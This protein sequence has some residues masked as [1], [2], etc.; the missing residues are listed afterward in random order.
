[1]SNFDLKTK[2]E[3]AK[4]RDGGKIAASV[5]VKLAELSK[6]GITTAELDSEAEKMI[7]QAGA[8]PSF[9]GFSGY[10]AATCISI[11]DEIVHGIPSTRVVKEGDLIGIDVGVFYK[12]FHTDT[13]ITVGVG[14]ILPE[15]EKLIFVTKASLETG[16]KAAKAGAHLGDIQAA[17][18]EVID[19]AGYGII[20]DLTGHGVGRQ[21]QEPP[22]IPNYGKRGTGPVLE[23]GM[24]IAIEPMVSLGDYRVE[25]LPD[26]WT[27][28]SKDHS[29]TAHF[30]HTIA[31]TKN[32]AEI[33]TV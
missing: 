1:M 9:K 25:I 15:E 30:E 33:L 20:R 18:Q 6:P 26:G 19:R 4:M 11:N 17:I 12:G 5:L 24:T 29:V 23:E 14:K 31:V 3:I 32:G 28:A 8:E 7:H 27:I 2:E 10:P 13:A 16:I 22:L 21:L